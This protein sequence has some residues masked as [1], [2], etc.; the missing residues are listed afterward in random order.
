MLTSEHLTQITNHHKINTKTVNICEIINFATNVDVQPNDGLPSGICGKC[1][2]DVVRAYEFIEKFVASD[3]KLRHEI[4]KSVEATKDDE[5]NLF[6]VIVVKEEEQNEYKVES[7]DEGGTTTEE[8]ERNSNYGNDESDDSGATTEPEEDNVQL[9][10]IIEYFKNNE[11]IENGKITKADRKKIKILLKHI[12][13]GITNKKMSDRD[14]LAYIKLVKTHKKPTATPKPPRKRK[15]PSSLGVPMLK[16]VKSERG[17]DVDGGQDFDGD[18]YYHADHHG[19]GDD[20]DGDL[21]PER[22]EKEK[23]HQCDVCSK[24]FSTMSNLKIHQRI[25]DD[26][27]PYLCEE[28]GK[29]FRIKSTYDSHLR[30]HKQLKHFEC[31]ECDKKYKQKQSLREHMT[32]H[33]NA[34]KE[35]DG[36]GKML[37]PDEKPFKCHICG[38]GIQTKQGF[39]VHLMIHTGEK[40]FKCEVCGQSMVLKAQLKQ[41]MMIHT[42]EKPYK[43]EICGKTMRFSNALV[44]HMRSHTGERPYPC[45]KCNLRFVSASHVADHIVVHADIKPAFTCELCGRVFRR[46]RNLSSH[47]KT[48]HKN[49]TRTGP[50]K[51][52]RPAATGPSI[53]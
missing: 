25:H 26:Y 14:I 27:K 38:A 15:K 23:K 3:R 46:K 12:P 9:S 22:K 41:H 29:S 40:P 36:E 33:H 42:G 34:Q 51:M 49:K 48:H 44:L 50:V 5:V 35:G 6:E 31:T 47:H 10:E 45:P 28:C 24:L 37:E 16:K 2:E 11:T 52:G 39:K 8:E 13:G 4:F 53:Y 43:C 7:E 30:A 19:D 32:N 1:T 18:V 21:A 17:A 20:Y